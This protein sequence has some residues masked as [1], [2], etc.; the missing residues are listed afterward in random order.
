MGD[1][2]A[3]DDDAAGRQ[4]GQVTRIEPPDGD[5]FA[6]QSGYRV[7]NRGKRSARLDLRRRGGATCWP[8][9]P[10]RMWWSTASPPGRSSGSVFTVTSWPAQPGLVTCSITGYGRHPRHRDRP[11]YDA[12]VAARTGLLYDQRAA[13]NPWSTSAGAPGRPGVRRTRGARPRRGRDG[14]LFPRTTWPS[15]GAT[16]LATL[17]IA[18]ALRARMSP[19]PASA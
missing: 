10:E 2:G 9:W 16:Y 5:P 19:V 15:I 7:W 18:A 8:W 14:P 6:G 11:G 3:Y 12:L 1:G 17:G 4:R 13:G